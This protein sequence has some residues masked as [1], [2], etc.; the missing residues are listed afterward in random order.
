MKKDKPKPLKPEFEKIVVDGKVLASVEL[1]KS[2][3][4]G[5]VPNYFKI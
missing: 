5:S 3:G 1:S 2:R 4:L